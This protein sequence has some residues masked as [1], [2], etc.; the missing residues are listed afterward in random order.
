MK[1]NAGLRG[2]LSLFP[3]VGASLLPVGICPA[4][5]PAYAGLLSALGLGFLLESRFLFPLTAALFGLALLSLGYRAR[6]RRG[7]RPLALGGVGVALVLGGKFLFPMNVALY[8]GLVIL[9]AASVWNSWPRKA[10]ASGSC[11]SCVPGA[12]TLSTRDARKGESS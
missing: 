9:V 5:W 1:Q 2:L 7:Y 4:C 11:P 6:T 8:A 3:G 12:G 10:S